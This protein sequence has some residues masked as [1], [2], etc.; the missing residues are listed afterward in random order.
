VVCGDVRFGMGALARA[1]DVDA[2]E[3]LRLAVRRFRQRVAEQEEV[4]KRSG[5]R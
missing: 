1:R 3:A 4:R 5:A 2:E